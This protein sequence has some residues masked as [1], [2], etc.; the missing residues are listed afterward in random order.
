MRKLYSIVFFAILLLVA[1]APGIWAQ[2]VEL[3]LLP[4]MT[5]SEGFNLNE[6][7]DV[8]GISGN[9]DGIYHGFF[10]KTR[11]PQAFQMIDL[12]TFGDVYSAGEEVNNSGLVVGWAETESKLYAFAWSP[13]LKA[14]V[15]LGA[16]PGHAHSFARAVCDIGLIAGVSIS[17]DFSNWKP[18]VW[19]PDQSGK[20]WTIHELNT[21]G[22]EQVTEWSC[23]AVKNAGQIVADGWDTVE[24]KQ[25]PVV[26]NSVEG[27]KEWKPTKLETPSDYPSGGAGDIN[28]RGEVVGW[29]AVQDFTLALPALW[30]PASP[31]QGP[32]KLNIIP[33]LAE[34]AIGFS[35]IDEI[36]DAGD[37][38]GAS[39]DNTGA[40]CA[41]RWNLSDL[42]TIYLFGYRGEPE[43]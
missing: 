28:E 23:W 30:Q 38:V 35:N 5:W 34:P 12:G 14:K 43:G 27:R 2:V 42:S 13:Y 22:L 3:G 18:V 24:L 16:L 7:G 29:V 6:A 20:T 11:G 33:T 37:M 8:V 19:T 17:S 15:D 10:V 40:T 32:W 31:R 26:W 39:V 1:S 25:Q 41:V 4:G 36:N 21:E 9:D